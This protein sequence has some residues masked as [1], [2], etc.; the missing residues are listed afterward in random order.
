MRG[1]LLL[2]LVPS[3][4]SAE[5]ELHYFTQNSCGPCAPV[6]KI[7][8]AL[9]ARDRAVTV[10]IFEENEAPFRA[11]NVDWMP[12]FIE[13]KDGKETRRW[14][15]N[16]EKNQFFNGD[17]V[18]AVAPFRRGARKTQ[19]ADC[20]NPIAK[21]IK[22]I[23]PPPPAPDLPKDVPDRV[24]VA[25]IEAL[26]RLVRDL[27]LTVSVLRAEMAEFQSGTA[28]PPGKDGTNGRNGVDGTRGKDGS[29]GPSGAPGPSGA[30]LSVAELTELRSLRIEVNILKT[31]PRRFVIVDGKSILGDLTYEPGE[32]VVIDRQV[33]LMGDE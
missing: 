11:N 17:F 26:E 8:R 21:I 24:K 3:M 19:P 18:S 5:T 6:T 33:I 15:Q 16:A 28:G 2:L 31:L 20:A 27:S 32:P 23:I 30:A 13:F 1:F 9:I 10:H 12:M 25:R 14:V 29:M 4:A 22:N 7:V